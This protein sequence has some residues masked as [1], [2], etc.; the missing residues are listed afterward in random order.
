MFRGKNQLSPPEDPVDERLSHGKT[1]DVLT[2]LWKNRRCPQF[3]KCDISGS[4]LEPFIYNGSY[5][6]KKKTIKAPTSRVDEKRTPPDALGLAEELEVPVQPANVVLAPEV[7]VEEKQHKP[8]AP[9][10][11]DDD[12]DGVCSTPVSPAQHGN[13]ETR[14]HQQ[15][16]KSEQRYMRLEG[17]KC[18]V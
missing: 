18:F 9:V 14:N 17:R 11:V 3:C 5:P 13:H 15:H 6:N 16:L 8:Q 2:V 10:R 4:S 1:G 7:E 12:S